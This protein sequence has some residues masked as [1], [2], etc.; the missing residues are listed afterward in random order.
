MEELLSMNRRADH[1][2]DVKLPC[3]IW[4]PKLWSASAKAETINLHRNGV[5]IRCNFP[6]TTQTVPQLG[7]D[8]TILIQLPVNHAFNGKSIECA[9]TLLR[10]RHLGGD[11][12]NMALR[13]QGFQFQD[14]NMSS[15][16]IP[17]AKCGSNSL[18]V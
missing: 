12:W 10:I 15:V 8:A 3:T 5:L 2:I 9:G 6:W 11:D 4:F 16:P 14:W 13:L 1:R 17:L 18:V 7:M